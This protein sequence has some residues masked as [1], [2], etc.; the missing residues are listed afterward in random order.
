MKLK[1]MKTF[2]E[3]TSELNISDVRSS[4]WVNSDDRV[5]TENLWFI[6]YADGVRQPLKYNK[7]N[8]FWVALAGKTYKPNEIERW[9]DA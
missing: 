8:Q 3:K 4:L 7:H 5:P 6:C 9:L 1:N 2:E